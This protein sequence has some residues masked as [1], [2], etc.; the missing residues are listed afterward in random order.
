[1]MAVQ[2]RTNGQRQTWGDMSQKCEQD[3]GS[4]SNELG[5][6]ASLTSGGAPRMKDTWETC[7]NVNVNEIPL[8]E[9]PSRR[10]PPSVGCRGGADQMTILGLAAAAETDTERNN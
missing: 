6:L 5:D 1:M 10:K 8:E 7:I 9:L 2:W 4:H 3:T